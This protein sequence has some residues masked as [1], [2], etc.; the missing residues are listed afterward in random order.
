MPFWFIRAAPAFTSVVN[1]LKDTPEGPMPRF[2][3]YILAPFK[4][5]YLI[6]RLLLRAILGK[7]K[8]DRLAK[9]F[10]LDTYSPSFQI[11][12]WFYQT[13]GSHLEKDGTHVAKIRVPRQ[14]YEY[15]CRLEKG[16]FTPGRE[17][18]IANLFAPRKGDT[19]V[20]VGAHIGRYT[21]SSSKRVGP[22]GK[23]IAIEAAPGN[24]DFLNRNIRLNH[25][26]NVVTLNCAAYS[27]QTKL[28][29]YEPSADNSIYDTVMLCRAG[30]GGSYVEVDATTL[31]SILAENGAGNVS[32]IKI[33][34]E[35][36]ELE[37]LKG[38]VNTLTNNKG[39]VLLVEVH[40]V[41]NDGHYPD[42]VRFLGSFGF[43][44][45]FDK[46]YPPGKERHVIFQGATE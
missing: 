30:Y 34:V 7:S 1:W 14:N 44:V 2:D 5:S 43:S 35:G 39:L 29:L 23:V 37:V 31:D 45:R 27:S 40:D 17:D 20:D 6:Q 24:F 32:W 42:I 38:S 41:G 8:R 9:K 13:F 4:L 15:Y 25:L 33:D 22:G 11:T 36:A 10:W 12:R 28:K 19:V 46:V 3:R 18:E 16:D 26:N 21:I